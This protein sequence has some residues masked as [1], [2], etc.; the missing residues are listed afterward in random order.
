MPKDRKPEFARESFPKK[1]DPQIQKFI[2][3]ARKAEADEDEAAFE[4]KLK[5]IVKQKPKKEGKKE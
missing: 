5:R 3:A 1:G 4:E 2:D